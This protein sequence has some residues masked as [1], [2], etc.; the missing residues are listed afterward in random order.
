[1]TLFDVAN[2]RIYEDNLQKVNNFR[3]F[4]SLKICSEI[5]NQLVD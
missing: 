1:M 3:K 5:V 4:N 2:I